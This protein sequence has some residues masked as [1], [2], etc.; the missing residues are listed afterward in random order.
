MEEKKDIDIGQII[1]WILTAMLIG[2]VIYAIYNK[3]ILQPT[4]DCSG[5]YEQICK[6]VTDKLN[7][8]QYITT[9]TEQLNWSL[10]K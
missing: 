10:G 4:C 5:S 8:S 3:W 2:I 1:N 6:I 7:N 9:G